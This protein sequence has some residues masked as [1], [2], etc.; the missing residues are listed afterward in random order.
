VS[1]F[2]DHDG[3]QQHGNEQEEFHGRGK[4]PEGCGSGYLESLV[5][6]RPIDQHW[7]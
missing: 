4:L 5:H 7:S 1:H 2:V 3:E 6:I